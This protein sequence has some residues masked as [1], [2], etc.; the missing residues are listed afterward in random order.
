[1]KKSITHNAFNLTFSK[2]IVLGIAMMQNM[3]L[4]RYA[5][6]DEYGTFSQLN[7]AINLATT[8][9]LI[10]LPNSTNY[11]LA[12][13]QNKIE[14]Q[15][16]LSLYFTLS[17]FLSIF[18]GIVLVFSTPYLSVFFE[19]PMIQ[20]FVFFLAIIPWTKIIMGS[21]DNLMI[22][23]NNVKV[24]VWYRFVNSIL[25]L[26]I[27]FTAF[28]FGWDFRI[29]LFVFM[30][31]ESLFTL[32]VYY[33]VNIYYGK[34]TLLLDMAYIK[35]VLYFS[36][37]LG[38]STIVGTLNVEMDKLIIGSFYSTEELAVYTNAARELPVTIISTSITAILLPYLVKFVKNQKTSSA[39]ELWKEF[40][41]I[42]YFLISFIVM[43]LFVFAPEVITFLY[44]EKYLGGTTVFRIYS[45]ILLL[46]STYYG[47]ILNS[48]GKTK[49]IFY[50]S[51]ISL[52][53]DIVLNVIFYYLFGF[54]GPA[55]STFVT[56]LIVALLQL[57]ITA[58]Q[59]N[60]ELRNIFPWITI[61][62]IT[63]F[64]IFNA[65]VLWYLDWLNVFNMFD[66]ELVESIFLTV[67]GSIFYFGFYSKKINKII[68]LINSITEGIN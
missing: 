38:L 32:I 29:Y 3:L 13:T 56:L 33:L 34:I 42:S 62:Q 26:V 12:N 51:I 53:V 61:F 2:A 48:L 27:I 22:Y 58:N 68:K 11:F 65:L 47:I 60:Y 10:G 1:M 19:N 67:I 7:I 4:S 9:F 24:L 57:K 55:I 52:I 17:T 46:R 28:Y 59:I 64:G 40:T 25:I 41:K 35:R 20:K 6:L 30:L 5:T 66:S 63:G 14:E 49:F 45:I 18:A 54:N 31:I 36:I 15:K 37:P 50:S 16:F 8:I 23:N 44:S 43:I 39:I 21:L